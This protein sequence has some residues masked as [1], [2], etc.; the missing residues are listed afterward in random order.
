M[1]LLEVY[2]TQRL[3]LRD[4]ALITGNQGKRIDKNVLIYIFN[5]YLK[6]SG[7]NNR[8][9]SLHSPEAYFRYTAIKKEC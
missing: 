7:I 5:N 6:I 1:E 4:K 9:Y 8:H 2:L 3:P